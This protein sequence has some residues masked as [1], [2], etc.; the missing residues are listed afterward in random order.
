MPSTLNT[1]FTFAQL[2]MAAYAILPNNYSG[3]VPVGALVTAGFTQDQAELFANS[4]SVLNHLENGSAGLSATLFERLVNGQPTGEKILAIRGTEFTLSDLGNNALIAFAGIPQFTP[5]YLA[6]KVYYQQ[7]QGQGFLVPNDNLTVTGHSLGGYLAQYFA[8]D[9][10]FNQAGDL[11]QFNSAVAH[12]YTFN[13]PGTGGIIA[14]LLVSAG[15][16]SPFVPND[17]ITNVIAENGLS[18]VAGLGV[19]EG[20]PQD[21]FIEQGASGNPIADALNDHAIETLTDSL[22]EYALF[23]QIDP[24]TLPLASIT[25]IL[26]A[27]SNV[28][29]NSLESGLDA[30]RKL[31]APESFTPTPISTST[32]D[33]QT[34]K[35]NRNQYYTNLLDLSVSPILSAGPY[36]VDSLTDD[37]TGAVTLQTQSA[38]GQAYRYAL[39]QLNP[40]A[41]IGETP[42]LTEAL[43]APHNTQGALN[44]FDAG[45]GIGL[46]TD[47]LTDR[48]DFLVKKIEFNKTDGGILVGLTNFFNDTHFK[49]FA[50]NYEVPA[51][52][53]TQ[54]FLTPREF[55]FGDEQSNVLTGQS[56]D[57]HLYGG[58]GHDVLMGQGGV[59][60][61]EGNIGNDILVGGTE[62]DQLKGGKGFDLYI[63]NSG[64]GNDK[65]EDSDG[66]GVIIVKSHLLQGGLHHA[67]DAPDTYISLDGHTQFQLS[68]DLFVTLDDGSQLTVNE[69]FV[70]GQ[71]GIRLHDLPDYVNGLPD[72]VF[73]FAPFGFNDQG[74]GFTIVSATNNIVHA[75]GGNDYVV[76]G[77]GHD[78]MFGDDGDDSLFG[79]GG[80]DRLVGGVGNDT[81]DGGDPGT[82]PGQ[83][84]LDGGAGDDV[85]Y[86]G[87]G[88]DVLL[89]GPG[90]DFLS[91]DDFETPAVGGADV[92]DGG[93]GA[94]FLRGG[95]GDDVLTGGLGDDRL[96]GDDPSDHE[97]GIA[98]ASQR[99]SL[100]LAVPRRE[101]AIVG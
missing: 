45:T 85:L 70:S 9:T 37:A 6:L 46:T 72:R 42:A 61:L 43:Y 35:D 66:Q 18:L 90:A 38:N 99:Y 67:T 81:L 62:N 54:I 59:G 2:S 49:D 80:D 27:A 97:R 5:Q 83:D 60:Y 93:D 96:F 95:I 3:E 56:N 100:S 91:A 8:Q 87:E 73:D 68:G 32:G 69:N 71:L 88:D 48:T 15:V 86:G 57:D 23:E 14:Q 4:Y 1:D 44:L 24:V 79:Q 41:I 16:L 26:N 77:I 29:A 47:Y 31:F 10:S 101:R 55:L 76:S 7:L 22:V 84:F 39:T 98:F 94:D 78:Q 20:V 82:G 25:D 50:T 17:R 19:Q 58:A 28:P 65:I 34:N 92:V 89:G 36:H 30:L 12:A 52:L 51:G 63:Y 53:F 74:N 11:S 40:F 13:A 75:F 33:T 21:T 64:D